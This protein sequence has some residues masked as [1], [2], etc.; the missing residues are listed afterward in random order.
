VIL[1]TTYTN[2]RLND[3]NVRAYSWA[4]AARGDGERAAPLAMRSRIST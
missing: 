1:H 4:T 2:R 3:F